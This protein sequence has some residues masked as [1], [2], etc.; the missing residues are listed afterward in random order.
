MSEHNPAVIHFQGNQ[1]VQD[2][3]P[4]GRLDPIIRLMGMT[5]ERLV[6]LHNLLVS[7]LADTPEP[8]T[9]TRKFADKLKGVRRTWA[10]LERHRDLMAAEPHDAAGFEM[11]AEELGAQAPRAAIRREDISNPEVEVT[12]IY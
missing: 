11:T 9:A 4:V 10:L 7:N 2:E 6:S 8:P 3:V 5:G 1:Y 12:P